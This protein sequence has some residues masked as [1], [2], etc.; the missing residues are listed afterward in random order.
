MIHRERIRTFLERGYWDRRSQ[1]LLRAGIRLT[2][3]LSADLTHRSDLGFNIPK[4]TITPIQNPD[5]KL[6]SIINSIH[7]TEHEALIGCAV[8]G[9]YSDG[10]LCGY[11]DFDGI[12]LVDLQ[13]IDRK[14][15]SLRALRN[16]ISKT[17][18]HILSIDSLQHH[19][20]HIVFTDDMAGNPNVI[21]TA[22]LG[23]CFSLLTP[24]ELPLYNNTLDRSAVLI[25]SQKLN[26]S[27][28]GIDDTSSLYVLKSIL[29][30]FL[31]LPALYLQATTGRQVTKSESFD[32]LR[33]LMPALQY[34]AIDTASRWRLGW[35]QPEHDA[36]EL[37]QRRKYI[38]L[39]TPRNP[40]CA[41]AIGF[42]EI[43]QWQLDARSFIESLMATLESG[44][45][46]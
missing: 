27:I 25:Y 31:L 20:W 21:P 45:Q 2:P 13:R 3:G 26:Q 18:P 11:S 19:G 16:I 29:S 33:K 8:F 44:F 23:A 40:R 38:H 4:T 41:Y 42:E 37:K 35:K 34:T 46:E 30:R 1:L 12:L 39:N 32:A 7:E 10:S 15:N 5:P 22:T 43:Q 17:E 24:F 14:K 6:N 28:S 36:K 9:S